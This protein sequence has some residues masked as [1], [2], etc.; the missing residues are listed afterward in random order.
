MNITKRITKFLLIAALAVPAWTSLSA[1]NRAVP[2]EDVAVPTKHETCDVLESD[3]HFRLPLQLTP[4][5]APLVEKKIETGEQ[6]VAQPMNVAS[7]NVNRNAISPGSN[8]FKI[9][10]GNRVGLPVKLAGKPMK[11][12]SEST[13][14]KT[15]LFCAGS[16]TSIIKSII[17]W[18]TESVQRV[19]EQT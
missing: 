15:A 13:C 18:K 19:S 2:P 10:A 6:N 11:T 5:N 8:V 1:Q 4:N 7:S 3:S 9:K 17:F 16:N 12:A 14:G